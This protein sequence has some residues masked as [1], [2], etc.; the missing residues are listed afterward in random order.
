MNQ[1]ILLPL[2]RIHGHFHE[3]IQDL[4]Y[5][6][7]AESMSEISDNYSRLYGLQKCRFDN[8][9]LQPCYKKLAEVI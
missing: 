6:H 9:A 2:R 8:Q 5:I 1:D 3:W 7:F 4:G